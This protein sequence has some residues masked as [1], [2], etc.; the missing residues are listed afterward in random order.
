MAKLVDSDIVG[1]LLAEVVQG[2]S[3]DDSAIPSSPAVDALRT[4]F[5]ASVAQ[6]RKEHPDWTFDIPN[7]WPEIQVPSP[8]K[9]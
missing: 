8:A 9:A 3:A 6:T 7:E 4:K 1:S 2:I 5:E